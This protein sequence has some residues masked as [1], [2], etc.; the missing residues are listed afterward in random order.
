MKDVSDN[1]ASGDSDSDSSSSSTTSS[2]GVQSEEAKSKK[3]PKA[4]AKRKSTPANSKPEAKK[5]GKA[6]KE[7]KQEAKGKDIGALME[8]GGKLLTLLTELTAPALWRSV[9]RAAE[10]DRR[11]GKAP[12][13]LQDL[14]DAS[15]Q[16]DADSEDHQKLQDLHLDVFNEVDRVEN[17]R[18][19]CKA[20]RSFGNDEM[21]DDVLDTGSILIWFS[22]CYG[23]LFR[24]EQVLVD[25]IVNIAKKLLDVSWQD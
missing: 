3:K 11:L 17:L 20:I 7:P 5:K 12:A 23:G 2:W 15:T 14:E 8:S 6:D 10:V 25:M 13:V 24:C 22:K 1:D 18:G 4:K 19:L 16:V 9:V 21:R